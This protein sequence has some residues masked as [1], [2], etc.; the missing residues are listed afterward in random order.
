M[1]NLHM[2]CTI[3]QVFIALGG[4]EDDLPSLDLSVAFNIQ[5]FFQAGLIAFLPALMETVLE[6]GVQEAIQQFLKTILRL[7]P[8][9]Y[10]F[11]VGTKAFYFERT[12]SHQGAK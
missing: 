9:F 7:G 10:A 1:R 5:F 8:L 2:Q 4:F 12:I 6:R 3:Q 11:F